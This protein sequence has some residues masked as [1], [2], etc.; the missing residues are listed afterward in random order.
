[1]NITKKKLA[2]A[3]L[4]LALC[5]GVAFAAYWIYSTVVH[6]QYVPPQYALTLQAAQTDDYKI[7]LTA[8]LTVT[9]FGAIEPEPVSGATVHFYLTNASGS[10]P[11]EIGTATTDEDGVA[12]Y[13]W[14][15][16]SPESPE[17]VDYYFMAGYQVTP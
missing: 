11:Q 6:V 14:T 8:T 16:P 12:V 2:I 4:A 10:N 7:T 5:I 1:M 13:V 15:V 17:P 3:A 9:H